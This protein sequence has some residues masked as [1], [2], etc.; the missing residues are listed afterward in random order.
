LVRI[1][2]IG[3]LG[4][5]L[6]SY[7]IK[8]T[9]KV[10]IVNISKEMNSDHHLSRKEEGFRAYFKDNNKKNEV[11]NTAIH[12]MGYSFIKESITKAMKQHQAK[13]VFVTNSRV[14]YVA[15]A[16]EETGITDVILIG[17]DFIEKNIEYLKNDTIDFLIC[18]KPQEQGYR[19]IMALYNSLVQLSP[20]EKINFMPIDIIT[21]ENY[22]FYKN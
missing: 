15:Q 17:Y 14:F 22:K 13:V 8:D 21:K 6:S 19:G 20:V 5:H 12:E 7:L 10:L 2:S 3:Y 11:F 18:Q 1:F 9:D 16:F 4:A